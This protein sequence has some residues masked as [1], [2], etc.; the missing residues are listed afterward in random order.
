MESTPNPSFE[1]RSE[2][3]LTLPAEE[4]KT[5]EKKKKNPLR[6]LWDIATW[7]LVA[8]VVVMAVALVGVRVMGYT[9][10]AILSPSMTPKY[11]VGDLIYVKSKDP[12]TI[13]PGEVITFVANEDLLVVTHRVD[14]VDREARVFF[15]KG[16]ANESRDGNPV[17]YENVVGVVAF[18]LPKLGYVSSYLTSE[19]GRYVGLAVL[20]FLVLLFILPELF[21]P[22]KKEA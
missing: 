7:L 5:P 8:A 14:G 4:T 3:T 6:L 15:T 21:K 13:E 16:D 22:E 9:P 10:F 12:V 18:S 11:E 20:F 2:E 17:L 19:S 1:E